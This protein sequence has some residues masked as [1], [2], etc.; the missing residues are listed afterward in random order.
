MNNSFEDDLKS[1]Y[2]EKFKAIFNTNILPQLSE[3]EKLRKKKI[4][5]F[6]I[7]SLLPVF[8][9]V[10]YGCLLLSKIKSADL[11][12]IMLLCFALLFYF[13]FIP[14]IYTLVSKNYMKKTKKMIANLFAQ[15]FGAL[16]RIDIN[17]NEIKYAALLRKS[18]LINN[19]EFIEIDDL[20]AGNYESTDYTFSDTRFEVY[21][22]RGVPVTVYSGIVLHIKTTKPFLGHTKILEK[23]K[24][25]YNPKKTI[26]A[27]IL[28]VII[29]PIL[30]LGIK[31]D[32]YMPFLFWKVNVYYVF[33]FLFIWAIVEI[34]IKYIK[35]KLKSINISEK[36]INKNFALTSSNKE[37]AKSL[38]NKEFFGKLFE[39]RKIY[40]TKSIRCA[41]FEDN[42]IIII[43]TPKDIFEFGTL[44]QSAY[45][46]ESYK[47]YFKEIYPIFRLLHCLKNTSSIS[48]YLK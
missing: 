21:P 32:P 45:N 27:L 22:P 1:K 24:F 5:L 16:D 44:F 2:W 48:E 43:G 42:I 6:F 13:P 20:Y 35:T 26:F 38:I 23:N 9:I 19:F 14:W 29:I 7:I 46:A 37:E 8:A 25:A 15:A 4:A 3:I 18:E 40:H 11:V 47:T 36:T 39:L 30:A 17:F 12:L 31:E 41:F 28:F 34:L 33:G 10:A